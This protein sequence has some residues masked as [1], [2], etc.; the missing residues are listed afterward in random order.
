[1]KSLESLFYST[2]LFVKINVEQNKLLK[3][4]PFEYLG[5]VQR[6]KKV[7]LC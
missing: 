7:T 1:M 6:I 2:K 3:V 5:L 4:F